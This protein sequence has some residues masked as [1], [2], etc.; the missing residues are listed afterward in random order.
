MWKNTARSV[1]NASKFLKLSVHAI[2][3]YLSTT[4]I[5]I[6]LGIVMS[7]IIKPGSRIEDKATLSY[8]ERSGAQTVAD[9]LLDIIRNT[10]PQNII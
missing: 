6:I 5:A 1:T 9:G 3:Y 4:V 2:G 8:S 7:L 10:F